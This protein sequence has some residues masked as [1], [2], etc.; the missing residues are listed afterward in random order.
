MLCGNLLNSLIYRSIWED[1]D[2]SRAFPLLEMR[3]TIVWRHN[4][5]AFNSPEGTPAEIFNSGLPSLLC[6]SFIDTTTKK[7]SKKRYAR[8]CG[9][10]RWIARGGKALLS[11]HMATLLGFGIAWS[12]W[13]F[14]ISRKKKFGGL[15]KIQGH[16][17]GI[18]VALCGVWA[19]G[20]SLAGRA[21][22]FTGSHRLRHNDTVCKSVCASFPSY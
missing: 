10:W 7:A 5:A 19:M 4:M 1:N 18:L 8:D 12:S 13:N 14:S 15:E 17:I 22:L 9:I 16:F 20:R 6:S 11:I 21:A 2:Q 3:K